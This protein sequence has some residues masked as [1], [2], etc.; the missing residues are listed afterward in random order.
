M[1]STIFWDI[2]GTLL[3]FKQV[4]QYALEQCFK[5]FHLG[6][7]SQAAYLHFSEINQRCWERLERGEL[8]KQDLLLLRFQDFFQ[9]LGVSVP[10]LPSINDRYLYY[11]G[12]K[13]IFNENSLALVKQLRGRQK[14]YAVTNGTALTQARKLSRSGL[15]QILDGIFISEQLGAEKPDPRFFQAIWRQLGSS[16]QK[17]TLIVGDSLTSDIL[18]GINA[19]ITTCWYNPSTVPNH[20]PIQPD[21]EIQSLLQIPSLLSKL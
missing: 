16:I 8:A 20:T 7:C 11:L 14:Q 10:S 13:I 3:N 2:D 17:T 15:D 21:Y 9:D 18:G 1:I 5:D 4:E 6:P 12:N 19:G